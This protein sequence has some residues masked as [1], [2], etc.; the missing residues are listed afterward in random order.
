MNRKNPYFSRL[1]RT[2]D[3][4]KA[5]NYGNINE[6]TQS[7]VNII[8]EPV[9]WAGNTPSTDAVTYM[10]GRHPIAAGGDKYCVWRSGCV[11]IMPQLFLVAPDEGP[12]SMK[13]QALTAYNE[14][15]TQRLPRADRTMVMWE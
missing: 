2:S 15:Y 9:A 10:R 11:K 6:M 7:A 5:V 3:C 1:S 4:K 14:A 12:Q 8:S 13:Q